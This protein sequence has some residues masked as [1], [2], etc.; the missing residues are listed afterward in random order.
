VLA[1]TA[2]SASARVQLGC[3]ST[4]DLDVPLG[5]LQLDTL[6]P[7]A[8]PVRVS[9]R[10]DGAQ[11]SPIG[12]SRNNSHADVSSNGPSGWIEIAR[13]VNSDFMANDGFA[14]NIAFDGGN[15]VVTGAPGAIEQGVTSG[16]VYV[17][18][19]D[20]PPVVYCTGKPNTQGCV[21][22]I[23]TSGKPTVSSQ[24]VDFLVLARDTLPS[25][26]GLFF[27][28]LAGP[29]S[30]PFLGGTLCVAPPLARTQPLLA[31]PGTGCDGGYAF[32]ASQAFF[33]SAGLD[34]G[35]T[36]HGQFW[37]RDPEHPDGTGA[38]LSNAV[39]FSVQP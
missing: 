39:E 38:A 2:A 24:D 14:E 4:I 9:L 11:I 21:P 16:A 37:M 35:E 36:V 33:D 13:L 22:K 25:K 17:H 8:V 32:G 7:L 29:A 23:A 28:G 3:E 12:G 6:D 31:S 19:I 5:T 20:V 27:Y 30:L 10:S 1:W 15:V 18:V 34:P 26:P